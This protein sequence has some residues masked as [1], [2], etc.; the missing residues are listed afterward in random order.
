MVDPFEALISELGI[1]LGVALHLDKKGACKLKINEMFDVQLETDAHQENLLIAAF[2]GDVPPGK[3]RENILRD[4]L[5]AN[6]P[7]PKNGTLAYSDRNNKLVLFS[8][9]RLAN[10]NGK[11]LAEFLGIFIDKANNWRIGMETGHTAHLISVPAKTS[12]G[13]FG[14]KP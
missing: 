12:D 2:I 8:Y 1:E 13:I 3:Y 9:F 5:K 10:L 6:W 14:M 4:T 7:F 11:K